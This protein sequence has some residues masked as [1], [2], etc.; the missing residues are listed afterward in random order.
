MKRNILALG[1]VALLL[2]AAAVAYLLRP[3][4][5][6]SAPIEA[7]PIA[8]STEALT[9][10]A[11][12]TPDVSSTVSQS[13]GT[14][15]QTSA[16]VIYAISQAESEVRF[17]IDELLRNIPTTAVGITNQVAG[18]IAVDL[19]DPTNSQVGQITVNAR[20]LA[21]ENNNRNRMIRNEILDTAEFEFI[22]FVPTGLSGLPET[23]PGGEIVSFQVTGDL[24]IRD[25]TAPV[26]FE[27]TATIGD[28]GKL[29]GYAITTVLRSV[30]E[31]IIPSVPSV[32]D[33]SDEVIVELEFVAYP[34]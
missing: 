26:T 28:D 5:E 15:I 11:A 33:V 32:A 9:E 19:S 4:K 16:P 23:M 20:T 25:I 22:T 17:S 14:E 3:S 13:T 18:E 21:T 2:A 1:L 34:K 12:D 6:A 7:E 27:V 10:P 8:V 30:Y 29:S 24:T 31:L